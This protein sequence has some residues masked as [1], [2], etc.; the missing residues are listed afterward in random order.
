MNSKYNP[1]EFAALLQLAIGNTMKKEFASKIDVSPEYLSRIL[2][3][4]LANPP[5][6]GKIQSIAQNAS[7]G[8]TYAQLLSAAGYA[9]QD[10][11]DPYHAVI[12]S[13]SENFKKF[14]QGTILTAL[15]VSGIPCTLEQEKKDTDYHLSV[16]FPSGAISH[17]HFIFLSNTTEELMKKD[18]HA[19]YLQLA[20][21][22]ISDT[23]KISFVTSSKEEFDLYASKIP[24]N[25]SLNLSVILIAEKNLTIEKECWIKSMPSLSSKDIS[26]Y[27]L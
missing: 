22:K 21:E 3:S 18:F 9:A 16:S 23:E 2:N 24:E 7:N 5:S 26:I 8:V 17:W 13:L 25:L 4:K 20:F 11:T 15:S 10:E 1:Q 14:M 12:A 6:I 27:T 19:L